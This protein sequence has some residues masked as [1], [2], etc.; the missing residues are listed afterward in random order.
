MGKIGYGYGSE[1]NLLRYLGYHRNLLNEIVLS[2]IGGEDI[3]WLDFNF[4]RINKPLKHERELKGVEFLNN[5]VKKSW[6]RF[7]PQSGNVHNWDAVGK[8]ITENK[9]K[10]VL[11]EAK[12]HIEE[13]SSTCGAKLKSREKIILA[14][15]KAKKLFGAEKVSV[16]KWLAPYYQFCNRLAILYFLSKECNPSID[17]HLVM[18][19]F[20]GDN[21]PLKECPQTAREWAPHLERLYSEIGLDFDSELMKKVHTIYVPVNPNARD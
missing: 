14:L 19:Y 1:W 13:I 12:S 17:S 7:W 21:V 10:W 11:I 4:T 3:Q 2:K 5:K 20:Y 6:K 15:E 9:Q 18:I 16:K 8:L